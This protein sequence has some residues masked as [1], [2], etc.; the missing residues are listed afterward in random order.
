MNPSTPDVSFEPLA[1]FAACVLPG[2]GHAARGE[3]A[4]GLAIGVGVLGLFA[5]GVL[6]GGID[7]VDRRE[8]GVWFLGQ[9][10]VGPVAI[11]TDYVHQSRFKVYDD[12]LRRY[13]SAYPGELRDP[14]SAPEP[15]K[16]VPS[17][18]AGTRT[19]LQKPNVKSVGKVNELG[20]LFTAL[21]GMLNL[22]A[23]I[24]AGFPTRRRE[25]ASSPTPTL[26]P[27][28]AGGGA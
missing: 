12:R 7:V 20:T 22:I 24:D 16:A 2:L 13:R 21:A 14:N 10:L 25:I 19:G 26:K 1:L 28:G 11:A 6:I 17:G 3:R 23:I 8:D 5:G 18:Q 15:G 9:A 4:R 27:A